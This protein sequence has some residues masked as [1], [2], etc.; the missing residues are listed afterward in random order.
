MRAEKTLPQ[1]DEDVERFP[2]RLAGLARIEP[3]GG[4]LVAYSAKHGQIALDGK[5]TNS[6][7]ARALV[8]RMLTPDLE[9]RKLFGLVRDDVLA[10]TDRMQE[11]FIDGTLG[12]EDHYINPR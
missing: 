10:A 11:P 5:G 2:E 7:F 9:S 12:G 8:K 4:T 1:Y 6:P 3:D